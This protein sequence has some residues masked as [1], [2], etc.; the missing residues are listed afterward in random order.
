MSRRLPWLLFV[1]SLALNI[2]FVVGVVFSEMATEQ[3]EDDPQ[4]G[5]ALVSESLGLSQAQADDLLAMRDRVRARW[6]TMREEGNPLRAA[7]LAELAKPEFDREMVRG[8]L[9]QR[10]ALFRAAVEDIM[11]EMHGYLATLEPEQKDAFI[12]MAQDRGFLRGLLGGS[13]K[14]S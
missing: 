10:S 5:V 9:D 13:R 6:S 4:A 8:I 3:L 14:R 7:A 1:V 11:A 2:F 12:E